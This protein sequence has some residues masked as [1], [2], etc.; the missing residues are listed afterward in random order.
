MNAIPVDTNSDLFAATVRGTAQLESLANGALSKGIDLYMNKDYDN[1]IKEFRRS[2][3]LSPNSSYAVQSAQ[4]MANAYLAIGDPEGAAK[5]YKSALQLDPS[6]DDLHIQLGNLYYAEKRYKEAE[7]AYKEGVRI[8]PSSSNIYALGQAYL[9]SGHYSDAEI[10]FSKVDRM[11]PQKPNGKYGMGLTY[12]KQGRYT[13]AIRQFQDAIKLDDEFY[14]AYAEIGYAYLGQ[15][16]ID[17]AKQQ[18]SL[19]KKLDSS[20]ASLLEFYIFQKEPPKITY[21][22]ID[23]TFLYAMAPG[24]KLAN[25]D[26]YLANANA[27]KTFTMTFQFD[28]QMDRESV[29]SKLNW[30]I[31]RSTA[32]GPGQAYNFGR[33][34]PE[35]EIKITPYPENVFYDSEK[36]T[37]TVY[38]KIKQNATADGTIDP[39][40]IEFRFS[41][42]DVYGNKIDAQHDQFTGFS[43]V[44]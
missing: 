33:T 29:E 5:T 6:R 3:G 23:S 36:L 8:N 27:E 9:S 35:T 20:L 12:S 13:E 30:Q 41:G 31:I 32:S 26:T 39:L 10:Q 44:A 40:H 28:K 2:M 16:Q 17:E 24:T 18:V 14:D 43:G 1:A 19:L 21:A 34:L 38:F 25:M 42:K 4:Y 22:H 7:E 11:E 15:G 37:A